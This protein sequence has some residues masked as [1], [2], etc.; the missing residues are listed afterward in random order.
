M[1][2]KF[3][4]FFSSLI[5]IL[6]IYKTN[7]NLSSP[8]LFDILKSLFYIEIDNEILR[9]I[10]IKILY[11]IMSLLTFY[12]LFLYHFLKKFQSFHSFLILL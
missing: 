5:K 8:N 12:Y 3:F 1:K 11:K 6:L 2:Q 9:G 10:T 4:F 7:A